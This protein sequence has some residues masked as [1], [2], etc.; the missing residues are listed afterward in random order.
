MKNVPVQVSREAELYSLSL[1]V[2]SD[3]PRVIVKLMPVQ[4][5]WATGFREKLDCPV[6]A[7]PPMT[8]TLWTKGQTILDS[9]GRFDVLLNGTLLVSGVEEGDAG[10]YF[11]T[12]VSALGQ[13]QP[14]PNVQVIVRGQCRAVCVCV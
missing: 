2:C 9:R 8:E 5:R 4:V 11:C 13:G 6:D 3:F 1:P 14:S 12:P 10:S 7:N